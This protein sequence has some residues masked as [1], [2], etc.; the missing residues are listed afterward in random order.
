MFRDFT[1]AAVTAAHQGSLI[2]RAHILET[3]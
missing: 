2:S 1:G 3:S